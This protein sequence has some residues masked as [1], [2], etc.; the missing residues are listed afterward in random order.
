MKSRWPLALIALLVFGS[1]F[2]TIQYAGQVS[3]RC[4]ELAI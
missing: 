2:R 1:A 4:D 3:L